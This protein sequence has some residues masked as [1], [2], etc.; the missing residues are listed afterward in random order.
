M[1]LPVR[2]ELRMISNKLVIIYQFSCIGTD[3]HNFLQMAKLDE[4]FPLTNPSMWEGATVMWAANG[5]EDK[6]SPADVAVSMAS[7]G[8]YQ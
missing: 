4:S 5:H 1:A 3:R 2:C 6:L 8:Y 7:S